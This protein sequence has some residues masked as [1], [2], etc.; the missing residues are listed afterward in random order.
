MK[1]IIMGMIFD[2]ENA[3]DFGS[4]YGIQINAGQF[5]AVNRYGL[6]SDDVPKLKSITNAAPGSTARCDDTG[7]IYRFTHVGWVLG[8]LGRKGGHI[9][10][11]A[12]SA[13]PLF[14]V[15][16][17]SREA[18]IQFIDYT[19]EILYRYTVNEFM[20]L[21]EMPENPVHEGLT[22]QGWNYTL[23]D[24]KNYVA[25]YEKIDI[26]Q[27]YI[28]EDGK[29]RLHLKF[30]NRANYIQKIEIGLN[31][32][33]EIDWGDG[34]EHTALTGD[35]ISTP[36]SVTHDYPSRW[37]YHK[38][39]AQDGDFVITLDVA[40]ELVFCKTKTELSAL[41]SSVVK[42]HLGNFVSIGDRAFQSCFSLKTITIP[43]GISK[44]GRL[45][46]SWTGLNSVTIPSSVTSIGDSAFSSCRKISIPNSI[47]Q[48][49][50]SMF[51][52]CRFL[53]ITLPDSIEAIGDKA[54]YWCSY[55]KSITIP[56]SVS[57]ISYY[58]FANCK[59]LKFVRFES[60]TP[61]AVPYINVWMNIPP[62]CV[63][64]IPKGS[65]TAYTTARNYPPISTYTYAEY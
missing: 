62:T 47:V 24:A 43:E 44:I 33:C 31:G 17:L 58:A 14:G 57:S 10:S 63:I 59:G 64:Y 16:Y 18:D 7:D 37:D 26:G 25:A 3:P 27:M 1:I 55:L 29:T 4:I 38:A 52:G 13:L 41:K 15:D 34:T 45:A 46:F 21:S 49:S 9:L 23:T 51:S 19:G 39:V 28:T 42:I 40:G 65:L 2:S 35:S 20:N 30:E 53:D 22:A 36:I 60:S 8:Q 61:P 54:F 56:A 11:S 48:I 6:N 50:S 32:T 5:P 12:V